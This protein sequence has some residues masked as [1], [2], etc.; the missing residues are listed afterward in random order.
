MTTQA[1]AVIGTGAMG[2]GMARVLLQGGLEVRV[3]N[4]TAERAAPLVEA[5]ARQAATAG[6]AAAGAGAVITMVADDAA[7]E[8]VTLGAGG[9]LEAMGEGAVHLSMSTVSPELS[10]RLAALHEERG[11]AYVAAPVFGRPDAAAAGKLWICASGA[12]AARERVRPLLEAMGQRVF[13]YGDDPGAA[14]VVK[15]AGNFTIIAA[16]EALA[17]AYTLAEKNGIERTAVH[18][19]FTSTLFACP[20]Y[21]RYGR[22]VAEHRYQPAGFRLTLGLKD[23]RLALGAARQ[24]EVPM[25]LGSL[26]HDRL[27][28]AVARGRAEID[29]AGMAL[30]VSEAAGLSP[31]P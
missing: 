18:E 14:N 15:L 21:E 24:S 11:Q 19:F 3:Y 20:I 16:T 30:E 29:V 31:A 10:R 2:A 25:P 27:L 13:P 28:S 5:G 12:A 7:L 4:R 17:E 1:V 6:E 23:I 22:A 8:G 9:I 26:L